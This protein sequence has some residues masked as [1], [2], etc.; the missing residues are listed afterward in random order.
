VCS[1]D[2]LDSTGAKTGYQ[3]AYAILGGV[4][5]QEEIQ[6]NESIKDTIENIFFGG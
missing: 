2:L 3:S 6:I 4:S 5:K 1:S